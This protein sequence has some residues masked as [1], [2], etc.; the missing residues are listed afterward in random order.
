MAVLTAI[1]TAT[2]D[3]TSTTTLTA[4]ADLTVAVAANTTY[5]V[6]GYIG[7]Y[8]QNLSTVRAEGKWDFSIPAGATGGYGLFGI[9]GGTTGDI[10]NGGDG[11]RNWFSDD[12]ISW[13]TDINLS[14]E[15]NGFLH[16]INGTLV[17]AGTAGN[18]TLRW[19]QATS[20]TF[21]AQ[22]FGGSWLMLTSV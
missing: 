12:F 17:V 8:S 10:I 20:E 19:A 11:P 22:I 3:R 15:S 2:E 7:T 4:D 13:T 18:F 5:I 9:I 1:K 21:P 16:M 14:G 6:E